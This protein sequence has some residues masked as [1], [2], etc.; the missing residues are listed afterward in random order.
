M[1]LTEKQIYD[2]SNMN[3]AAQ[4]ANLGEILSAGKAGGTTKV[5]VKVGK[6]TTGKPGT[7]A[8]VENIGTETDVILSFTIPKGTDG[9]NGSNGKNGTTPK[10]GVDYFTSDD[11]SEMIAAFDKIPREEPFF[12]TSDG[13]LYANGTHIVLDAGENDS[14]VMSYYNKDGLVTKTLTGVSIVYGGSKCLDG[15]VKNLASTS[16]IINGG[17]YHNVYAGSIGDSTVGVAT[18]I[19]NGGSFD[20][21]CGGS[22]AWD[23]DSKTTHM[24]AVG[25]SRLIVNNTDNI[26]GLLFGCGGTGYTTTGKSETTINGGR[27][28]YVTAG[29]SNGMVGECSLTF[30]TDS[31][32]MATS[33]EAKVLEGGCRGFIGQSNLYVNSGVIDAVYACVE[34][35]K[36]PV[37]DIKR[38][39]V[40]VT[41]GTIKTL[42]AGRVGD[43]QNPKN[44]FCSYSG[45][46]VITTLNG[47][48]MTVTMFHDLK[49]ISEA[50]FK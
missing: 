32:I 42:G 21:I 2:L 35:D 44:V 11:I 12:D 49:E 16:V 5:S 26:V 8:L 19:I 15:T 25:Y 9:K 1:S 48:N 20:A 47:D 13:C 18:M 45:S 27:F 46:P 31:R 50:V 34:L 29:S 3:V 28:Q 7:D 33:P 39:C 6:T 40:E 24:A 14:V 38:S 43:N 10:K 23:D 36:K 17:T 41:G 4:N 37:A 22:C 30:G